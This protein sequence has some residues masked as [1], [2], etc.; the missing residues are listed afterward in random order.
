MNENK[1]F[2]IFRSFEPNEIPAS[3]PI[4]DETTSS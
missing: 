1:R 4:P 3:N 2:S